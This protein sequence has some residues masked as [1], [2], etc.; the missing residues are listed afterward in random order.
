MEQFLYFTQDCGMPASDVNF[1]NCTNQGMEHVIDNAKF[2]VI[3]FT[4]SSKV[5]EHLAKKTHGRIKI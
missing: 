2:K 5:A 1:L 3:Q 4:G